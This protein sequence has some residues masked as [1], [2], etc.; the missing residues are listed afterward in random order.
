MNEKDLKLP[1]AVYHFAKVSRDINKI[2]NTV[3]VS[4]RTIRRWAETPEWKLALNIWG[5]KGDRSFEAQPK[6]DRKRDVGEFY[7]DAKKVYVRAIKSGHSARKAPTI[8]EEKT[9]IP[10]RRV[11][12]WATKHHWRKTT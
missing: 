8:T 4:E 7:G 10:R 3:Q 5:Y 11:R 1:V 2:A 6:R 9:G 12:V